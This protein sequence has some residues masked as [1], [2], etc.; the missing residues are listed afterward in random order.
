M[1]G[2]RRGALALL[3]ATLSACT[4]SSALFASRSGISIPAG[5]SENMRIVR[6]E[7]V[8][9]EP[10]M[11][12]P[13]NVWADLPTKRADPVPIKQATVAASHE[14]TRAA[15]TVPPVQ[16]QRRS[17]PGPYVV[18]LT[19]ANSEAAARTEWRHLQALM[20]ELMED[21]V[22]D[23]VPAEVVGRSLCRLRIGGFADAA[24]ANAFC[25]HMHAENAPCWVVAGAS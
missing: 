4:A 14:P 22:P 15:A 24:D 17:A 20:P 11:S 10:L 2:I 16:S 21:R 13:G 19:A 6:G 8:D 7:S 3:C 1:S 12:E 23:V 18:Q 5:D 9:V 25:A